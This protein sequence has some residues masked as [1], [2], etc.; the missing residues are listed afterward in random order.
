MR[1]LYDSKKEEHKLPFGCVKQGENVRICIHI[2]SSCGAYDVR[3]ITEGECG[4]CFSLIKT[5]CREGYDIFSGDIVFNKTGLYLYYFRISDLGGSYDLLRLGL[6]DTN[7]GDGEKWQISCIPKDFFVPREYMGRVM[8][9]IFPDRFEIDGRVN[10]EGKLTPFTVHESVSEIPNHLPDENGRILNND[11]YGGNL[12]GIIKRLG[13]LADLGVGII[14]LNPIFK[15]YSNHRYDTCDYMQIDPMLG[16]EADFRDL[17]TECHKLNMRVILDGVFSHTGSDSIYFDKNKRFGNGAYHNPDSPYRS[18]YNINSDGSYDSWWGIDTL[19]CVNENDKSYE[20]YIITGKN[21]VIRHWLGLGA[22]GFRLDVADELPDSFIKKL[23]TEAKKI[24]PESIIIGEVW[25][26]ASNKTAYGITRRY[27]TDGELDTVM[28]YPWRNAI[29]EL[30]T[31]KISTEEFASKILTIVENYPQ[32]SLNSLMNSLSTHDTPR[33]INLL[34]G[35]PMDMSRYANSE[36]TLSRD[37]WEKAVKCLPLAVMLNFFL[38]GNTCIYYGDEAGMTGFS[39]P[40][41]RAFFKENKGEIYN[42]FK[43]L[44]RIKNTHSQFAN[45]IL[46]FVCCENGVLVMERRNT[47]GCITCAVNTKEESMRIHASFP[48]ITHN[49]TSYNDVHYIHKLGFVLF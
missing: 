26:D 42:L 36:Y 2:P 12:R 28:N 21:S 46:S 5:D 40:F 33:I 27:F 3:L 29:T 44:C 13:Y 15:A 8:Y 14:Y 41:N 37:E 9:Q 4:E 31:D 7:I 18:W 6:S 43:T 10:T 49:T 30:V 23:R 34:S 25:E 20:E 48:L 45:G 17:C 35:A 16:N 32:D 19:P 38:P 11:F 1:I 47:D 22:D 24:N 39:D